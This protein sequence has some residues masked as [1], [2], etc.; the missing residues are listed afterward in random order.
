[1]HENGLV[2]MEWSET[3]HFPIFSFFDFPTGNNH[4]EQNLHWGKRCL[5]DGKVIV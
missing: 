3:L 4:C 1:M 2:E 5:T